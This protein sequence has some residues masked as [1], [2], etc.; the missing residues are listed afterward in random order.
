VSWRRAEAGWLSS[1]LSAVTA[2]IHKE[3]FIVFTC[4]AGQKQTE[5]LPCQ[6]GEQAL[7]SESYKCEIGRYANVLKMRYTIKV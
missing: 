3:V 7:T 2:F 5:S 1:V 6:K 4:C